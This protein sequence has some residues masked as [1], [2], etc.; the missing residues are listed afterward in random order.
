MSLPRDPPHPLPV[1]SIPIQPKIV[2]A[3]WVSVGDIWTL[4]P[5]LWK[6]RRTFQSWFSGEGHLELGGDKGLLLRSSSPPPLW[7]TPGCCP[8]LGASSG[9][10]SSFVAH[11]CS[12]LA[13]TEGPQDPGF[14][15]QPHPH[16][17]CEQVI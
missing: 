4:L 9:F 7:L 12:I 17:D 11:I 16:C 8:P 2:D 5:V 1:H 3:T 14:E 15:S 13:G 6:D 10:C